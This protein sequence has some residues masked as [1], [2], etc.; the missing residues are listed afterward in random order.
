MVAISERWTMSET[1]RDTLRRAALLR[2]V[3]LLVPQPGVDETAFQRTADH[4]EVAAVKRPDDGD[5]LNRH[6]DD[7]VLQGF[8]GLSVADAVAILS[9]LERTPFFRMAR[10][11]AVAFFYSEM[12]VYDVL[13]YEGPSFDKGG[14]ANRGFNDLDWLP[15]PEPQEE[16][17]T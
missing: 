7:L 17:A 5:L 1:E 4:L 15:D 13:G 14:Y 12:D 2:M 9:N 6:L 10:A 8:V 3:H 11:D 16:S